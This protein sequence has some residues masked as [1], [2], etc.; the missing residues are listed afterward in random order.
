MLRF[1]YTKKEAWKKFCYPSE[2]ALHNAREAGQ[3]ESS[4]FTYVLAPQ[5]AYTLVLCMELASVAMTSKK[6]NWVAVRG[7]EK[8]VWKSSTVFSLSTVRISV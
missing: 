2:S 3:D 1:I 6:A 8:G 4:S 5:L 7:V